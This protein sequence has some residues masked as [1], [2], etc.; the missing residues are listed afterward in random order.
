M[1]YK[2]CVLSITYLQ[3]SER[4]DGGTGQL[5]SQVTETEKLLSILKLLIGKF[6][7]LKVY[8]YTYILAYNLA[9][10]KHGRLVKLTDCSEIAIV[11]L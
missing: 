3:I 2:T 11:E 1:F 9:N 4:P 10:V 5:T 8:S 6:K 7:A